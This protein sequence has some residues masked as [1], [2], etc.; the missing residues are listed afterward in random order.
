MTF[1]AQ[2]NED[3]R[4]VGL[5]GDKAD[6]FYIDV[7]AW[8]PVKDSVTKHFY[9][10]GWRGINIEPLPEYHARLEDD[11]LGDINLHCAV[12]D[13]GG[14]TTRSLFRIST[15][16][17]AAFADS[18][19]STF[20]GR[21]ALDAV[22]RAGFAINEVKVAVFTLAEICE[23]YVPDG[24]PIDFCKI[25]VEGWE[26]RVIRGM[27]WYRWRPRILCIEAT[28]PSSDVPAWDWEPLIFAAGYS[29]IEFDGLNRW[30]EDAR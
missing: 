13:V 1:Y 17:G 9:E 10:R 19:L 18:G 14:G 12:D 22:T 26:E 6:G 25:D 21:N 4:L 5:L 23:R 7:G 8:D 29:F 11:R 2:F 30:Y 3:R 16:P 24:T 20:D 27:D 15:K 28:L